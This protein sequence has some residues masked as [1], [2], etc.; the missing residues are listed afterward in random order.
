M[1][2]GWRWIA[3]TPTPAARLL[4]IRLQRAI[5]DASRRH[6][7]TR[8]ACLERVLAFLSDGHTAGEDMLME[9]MADRPESQL[10]DLIQKVL[11][12][13]HQ[14][15]ELE[16]RLTGLI[17]FGPAQPPSCALASPECRS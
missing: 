11:R 3:P 15:A 13:A 10:F 5:A 2:R 6:Q 7:P 12:T 4:S 17:V 8:L 16:A 9:I 1:A 14:W